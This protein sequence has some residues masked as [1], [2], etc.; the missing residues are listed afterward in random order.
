[1]QNWHFSSAEYKIL[2]AQVLS[3]A[4]NAVKI[5]SWNVFEFQRKIMLGHITCSVQNLELI[6]Q[7]S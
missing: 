6:L 3:S 7:L 4:V 2:S 1:M 5:K